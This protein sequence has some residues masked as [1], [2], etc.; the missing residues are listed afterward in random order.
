MEDIWV[1]TIKCNDIK[2]Q[3]NASSEDNNGKL[4]FQ[5]PDL[6]PCR[7]EELLFVLFS[8]QT[9]RMDLI[10][11]NNVDMSIQ[12]IITI[13][14]QHDLA[15]YKRILI[16]LENKDYDDIDDLLELK[17]DIYIDVLHDRSICTFNEFKNMRYIL[18][19]FKQRF[20]T[21]N[22]T[23]LEKITIAYDYVKF[24]CIIKKKVFLRR[25]QEPLQKYY[26]QAI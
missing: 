6:G 26:L 4:F 17:L 20:S 15:N 13:A 16:T 22:L 23:P 10:Q 25:I 24:F 7:D 11:R 1:D 8:R 14:R 9:L 18:R 3:D 5:R 21:Y 2:Y 12:D 19:D